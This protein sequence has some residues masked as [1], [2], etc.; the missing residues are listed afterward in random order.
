[1]NGRISLK[2][3]LSSVILEGNGGLI[4]FVWLQASWFKVVSVQFSFLVFILLRAREYIAHTHTP[5]KN[6]MDTKPADRMDIIWKILG[7]MVSRETETK[8]ESRFHLEII[9]SQWS[10]LCKRAAHWA[11]VFRVRG[12]FN[13]RHKKLA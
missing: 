11:G 1:M 10:V 6:Q 9:D 13:E 5:T 7:G 2:A 8:M 3:F 4:F 12:S